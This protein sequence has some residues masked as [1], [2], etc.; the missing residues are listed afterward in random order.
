MKGIKT[1][2]QTD[3][4]INHHHQHHHHNKTKPYTPPRQENKHIKETKQQRQQQQP[5]KGTENVKLGNKQ[6]SK[7]VKR[8]FILAVDI[9]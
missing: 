8:C 7:T 9:H 6:S 4:G 3:S 5:E 2:A 1:Q